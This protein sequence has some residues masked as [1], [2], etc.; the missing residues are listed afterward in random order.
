MMDAENNDAT[1]TATTEETPET[2]EPK[3][4]LKRRTQFLGFSFRESKPSSEDNENENSCMQKAINFYWDNEFVCLVVLVICLARA[5]PPLGADYLQPQILSTW[6]AVIFIF[7]KSATNTYYPLDILSYPP[8]LVPL[9][10]C[11]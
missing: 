5:Y 6:V 2:K 8:F 4:F 7:G 11:L 1:A 3:S 10:R 9:V